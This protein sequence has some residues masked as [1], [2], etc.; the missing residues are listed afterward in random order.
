MSCEDTYKYPSGCLN[1]NCDYEAMWSVNKE[2]NVVTFTVITRSYETSI[3]SG[4]GFSKTGSMIDADVILGYKGLTSN[5][6]SVID[7]YAPNRSLIRDNGQSFSQG[8]YREHVTDNKTVIFMRFQ[9][10]LDTGDK[11]Q[12]VDLGQCV[13]FL[14]PVWPGVVVQGIPQQHSKAPIVS[15]ENMCLQLC[16]RGAT[17]VWWSLLRIFLSSFCIFLF[18]IVM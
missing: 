16:S 13:K 1:S 11:A 18:N 6:G 3:W 7:L 8:E 12:D 14:Y 15:Q 5:V 2:K 9:R 17:A 4:I 10:H